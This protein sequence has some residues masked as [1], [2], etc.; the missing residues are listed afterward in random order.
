MTLLPHDITQLTLT[1]FVGYSIR[2]RLYRSIL[3]STSHY[4]ISPESLYPKPYS[5]SQQPH[6]QTFKPPNGKRRKKKLQ[7]QKNFFFLK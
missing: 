1:R 4:R 7:P 3:E 5:L 2:S 6:L